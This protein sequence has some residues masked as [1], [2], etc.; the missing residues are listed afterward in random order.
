M[1]HVWDSRSD[2]SNNHTYHDFHGR[3]LGFIIFMGQSEIDFQYKLPRENLSPREPVQGSAIIVDLRR[4][5]EPQHPYKA[6][7]YLLWTASS[8]TQ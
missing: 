8:I 5:V 4:V 3:R 7:K 1:K 6:Y 2:G